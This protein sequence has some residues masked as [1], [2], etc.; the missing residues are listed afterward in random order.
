MRDG[1][2]SDLTYPEAPRIRPATGNTW[3]RI[4][5]SITRSIPTRKEG[6]AIKVNEKAERRRS[7]TPP[8]RAP[9]IESGTD[10]SS[11]SITER[12]VIPAVTEALCRMADGEFRTVFDFSGAGL[13]EAAIDCFIITRSGD[14]CVCT[15]TDGFYRINRNGHVIMHLE[16]GAANSIFE[17]SKGNIWIA[18][19]NE[20]VYL[21]STEGYPVTG[22]ILPT[23]PRFRTT[24]SV[25]SARIWTGISGWGH[26]EASAGMIRMKTVLSGIN[27]DSSTM[28]SM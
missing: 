10:I 2:K 23:M 24:M 5:S 1:R 16:S 12:S 9:M 19:R 7:A 4:A 11:D 25:R 13:D 3:N 20:G 15:N 8:L 22:M 6:R 14:M 17:D 18:S 28:H 21:V 26:T 27:T